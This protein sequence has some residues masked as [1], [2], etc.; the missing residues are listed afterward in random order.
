MCP[1]CSCCIALEEKT[2]HCFFFPTSLLLSVFYEQCPSWHLPWK[3]TDLVRT[4][5]APYHLYGWLVNFMTNKSLSQVFIFIRTMSHLTSPI[6]R[7]RYCQDTPCCIP[8]CLSD[9]SNLWLIN[10]WVKSLYIYTSTLLRITHLSY[11]STSNCG[12][13]LLDGFPV[14]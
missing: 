1:D 12:T 5:P 6:E 4:L 13:A 11:I 10:L 3:E 9:L 2:V 8:F 14:K 7:S